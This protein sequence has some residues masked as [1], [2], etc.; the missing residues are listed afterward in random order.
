M[1]GYTN[2]AFRRICKEVNPDIFVFT[3]FTSAEGLVHD[4][5]A[6]KRRFAYAPEEQPIIAQIFGSDIPSFIHAAQWLEQQGFAGVDINMGC[7]SRKVVKSECGIAL[8]KDHALAF[9]LVEA[10]AQNTSLPV[11][12]KTRLGLYDASDLIAFGQGCERAGA[13]MIEIHGRTY[14]EPYGVPAHFDPIYELKETVSIPVLGNGGIRS[15]ADGLEK[16]GNLDGFMIGQA[17]IGNPWAFTKNPTIPFDQKVQLILR[18]LEY[19]IALRGTE[20]GIREMRKHLIAYTKHLPRAKEFRRQLVLAV[21]YEKVQNILEEIAAA[22]IHEE[23][24]CF[25]TPV[26]PEV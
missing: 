4:A 18:H 17:A 6:I 22:H 7:P 16:M 12:V 15:V 11:S 1:D 9:K 13:N 23:P 21:S 14:D 8:R 19:M 25:V 20:Y 2:S 26:T 10:V 24:S 3:E 5:D